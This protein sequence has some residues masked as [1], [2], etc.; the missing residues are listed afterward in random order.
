LFLLKRGKRDDAAIC[1]ASLMNYGKYAVGHLARQA[2]NDNSRPRTRA[3]EQ[4]I[5]IKIALGASL[6]FIAI[7]WLAGG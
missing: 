5:M 1:Y 4:F 7:M 3:D 2:S 6:L